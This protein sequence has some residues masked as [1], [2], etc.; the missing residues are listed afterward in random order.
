MKN[1]ENSFPVVARFRKSWMPLEIVVRIVLQ[2]EPAAGFQQVKRKNEVGYFGNVGQG[3]RRPGKNVVVLL[4]AG[5]NKAKHIGA[6]NAEAGFYL[7]RLCCFAH[8]LH[9]A[10][11]F[12]H[13]S[14]VGAA[15]GDEFITMIARAAKEIE[16]LNVFKIKVIVQYI[17]QTFFGKVC[18]RA[19]GP[20]VGRREEPPAFEFS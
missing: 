18:S 16:H 10:V 2:H 4:P 19:G 1:A 9:A 12:V 17:E 13:I 15:S 20:V 8:K 7:K 5:G 11:E 6:D 3:V 14:D